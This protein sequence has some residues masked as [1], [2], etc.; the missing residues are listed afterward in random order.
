MGGGRGRS[1]AGRCASK[2]KGV[3]A[4][5]KAV[6][7]DSTLASRSFKGLSG[8][9][10]LN[11]AA[12][13]RRAFR[14]ADPW[15]ILPDP[16][17]ELRESGAAQQTRKR[18]Q[19]ARWE[20]YPRCDRTAAVRRSHATGGPYR[21]ARPAARARRCVRKAGLHQ[22]KGSLGGRGQGGTTESAYLPEQRCNLI[23]WMFREARFFRGK[24]NWLSSSWLK[25]SRSFT[26]RWLNSRF[27]LYMC[28]F[29]TST[30]FQSCILDYSQ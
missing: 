14:R 21:P 1:Y 25:K 9:G 28:N 24:K 19:H 13:P 15:T 17:D 3:G 29:A 4:P 20:Y 27:Q 10:W 7:K 30:M 6:S 8:R 16:T 11:F 22:K 26:S 12:P 23:S 5:A 18:S 2:G